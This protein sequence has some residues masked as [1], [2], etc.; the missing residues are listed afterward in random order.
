MII[1]LKEIQVIYI[2]PNHNEKYNKRKNHMDQLLTK[3]GFT[4]I[5][6]YKSSTEN[7]PYCLNKASIDIFSNYQ[8]PYLLLEDDI[9]S[10]F[11]YLPNELILPDNTDAFYLGLSKH[12]GHPINNYDEGNSKFI[13]VNDSLLKVK[14]MLTTHAVLYVTNN[15]TNKLKDELIRKSNYY[16]DVLFSQNQS[17]FNVYCNQYCYFYQAKEYEG[18]ERATRFIV[19]PINIDNYPKSNKTVT[20]V[21]AFI[22]ISNTINKQAYFNDFEKLAK[23][24]IPITLFMDSLEKEYGT[25]LINTYSNVKIIRYLTKDELYINKLSLPLKLPEYRNIEK[26]TEDYLK[27]MNNKIF[28]VEEASKVNIFNTEVFAWIDF[29]IFHII[30]DNELITKKLQDISVKKYNSNIVE[31]AGNLQNKNIVLDKINWRF[32]GGYFLIGRDKIDILIEKTKNILLILSTL[33]W[34]VNIWAILEY[35]N[36]FEFGWYLGN[37][38]NFIFK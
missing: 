16:N 10:N 24:C 5:I 33:T 29:R 37:H 19:D 35:I 6:H 32:L 7:Y 27:L 8:P 21:T 31:F 36:I 14:N 15:Y 34:E 38:N 3:L 23:T 12:G 4:N 26:D 30:T 28:F 13:Y 20:F 1:K 25:Q 18:H 11:D 22:N 17:F 9:E 2:S